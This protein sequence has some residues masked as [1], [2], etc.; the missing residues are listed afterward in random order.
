MKKASIY[1]LTEFS[2]LHSFS[3]PC[4]CFLVYLY[5]HIHIDIAEDL[6]FSMI[7]FYLLLLCG[8][9]ISLGEPVFNSCSV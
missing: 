8:L 5:V 2:Y 6:N 7:L 9:S 4:H 3:F 1:S